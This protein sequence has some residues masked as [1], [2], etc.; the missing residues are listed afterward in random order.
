MHLEDTPKESLLDIEVGSEQSVMFVF[1]FQSLASLRSGFRKHYERISHNEPSIKQL[2][3]G[4]CHLRITKLIK[5]DENTISK[6]VN[7][8]VEDT[9]CYGGKFIN[10]KVHKVVNNNSFVNKKISLKSKLVNIMTLSGDGRNFRRY[11][12]PLYSVLLI[13]LVVL[14]ISIIQN[15]IR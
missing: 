5:Y 6:T 10:W 9:Q 4:K 13:F 2:K 8:L 12:M 15:W 11:K 3:N 1:E 7:E 14:F